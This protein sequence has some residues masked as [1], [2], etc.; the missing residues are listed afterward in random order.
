VFADLLR[1]RLAGV[2]DLSAGQIDLLQSH[3]ELLVRWNRTLNLTAIRTMEEAVER[4]YCESVFLAVHLPPGPLRI[5][6]IGSGGGFPGF[7]VAVLRPDCSVTLIESHRRKVVFLREATRA[8]PNVRVLPV[9]GEQVTEVFDH[10]ISRAVSCEDLAPML[11]R[12]AESADLLTGAEAPPEELGFRWEEPVALPW[13]SR[14]F[15]RIG[16]KSAVQFARGLCE[17]QQPDCRG[18]GGRRKIEGS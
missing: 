8:L 18:F 4:H 6:D 13:G 14:R 7:P 17:G 2:A 16:K 5:A 9:R 15:L 12:I 1:S 10:A 11:M 3:Y